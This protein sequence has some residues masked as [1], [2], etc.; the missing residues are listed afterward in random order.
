MVYIIVI[1][2]VISALGMVSS[3]I[4][5]IRKVSY[6]RVYRAMYGL[7]INIGLNYIFIPKFG[8]LGA[9]YSSLLVK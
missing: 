8:I 3:N 9:A 1:A 5:I 2:N 6:L 7:V 4:L